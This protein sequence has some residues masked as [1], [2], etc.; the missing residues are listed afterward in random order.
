MV[1]QSTRAIALGLICCLPLKAQD[2]PAPLG[3]YFGGFGGW[4]VSNTHMSQEGTA[5]LP[6]ASGGEL[7][8]DAT[9]TAKDHSFGFGG[10]HLGYE[11]FG[12]WVLTPGIEL[13]GYYFASTMKA[14]DLQNDSVRL[15][16][17][18]FEVTLP[19]RSG[20]ILANILLSYPNK[21]AE[22][23]ISP[24]IGVGI[25]HIHD[26]DSKQIKPLEVGINHFNSDTSASS[27]SF[28]L[29]AK[30]GVRFP[31]WEYVRPF[32]EY[33]FLYLCPLSYTFGATEYPT[34]SQTS[35][36]K[37]KLSRYYTN[38]FSIGIDLTF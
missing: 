27:S 26:A 15:S 33:R 9:G 21:Y 10:L 7:S 22:P 20:V 23:Y 30:A 25:T 11:W 1:K 31:I 2:T 35:S 29:Q 38:L 12:A 14:K 36:W 17:H 34:H 19:M 32:V 6:A 37:V 5:Y 18:D 3:L 24:G 8:V 16:H 28:A 13:E 4:G